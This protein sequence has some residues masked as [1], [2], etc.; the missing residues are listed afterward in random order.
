M[1][2]YKFLRLEP[3]YYFCEIDYVFKT[4]Q[5]LPV[6]GHECSYM[7][8]D[9]GRVKSLDRIVKHFKKGRLLRSKVL[10]QKKSDYLRVNISTSS[11]VQ[12]FTTHRLVSEAFLNHTACGYKSVINHINM[13]KHDNKKTNL[14]IT[15]QRDNASFKRLNSSS[16]YT[17]V[18]KHKK[19]WRAT[20]LVNYKRISLGCFDNEYDAHLAYQNKLSS[21]G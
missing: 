6:V 5:W 9:L 10:R 1:I 4:E 2:Y 15:T 8:S 7:V 16:K 14:E 3:I 21:L 20:I 11:D 19:S 13:N 18:H 12:T 17:G